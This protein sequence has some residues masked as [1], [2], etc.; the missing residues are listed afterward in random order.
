MIKTLP[1]A[2][3]PA[4]S[5]PKTLRADARKPQIDE[6]SAPGAED[7]ALVMAGLDNTRAA[8]R[9]QRDIDDQAALELG[10]VAGESI[11]SATGAEPAAGSGAS[12]AITI[13]IAQA[14]PAGA[15]TA[16]DAS[17]KSAGSGGAFAGFVPVAFALGGLGLIMSR[18]SGTSAPAATPTIAGK[19]VDGYI[20]GATV[21]IDRNKNG[22]LD[23]DEP[24]TKSDAQGNFTLP[25]GVEGTLVSVGGRDISTNLDFTGV[26]KAPAGSTAVTPLTT[27]VSE[28]M[29]SR[30]LSAA[31]A[32]EQVLDAV[33]L[34]ALKGKVD[35]TTLDPVAAATAGTAGALD[36]Q[37]AGVAVASLVNSLAV[38]VQQAANVGT[39]KHDEIA[40]G[41][42]SELAK[43]IGAG[44]LASDK[45]AA[46]ASEIVNTLATQA[47]I[48]GVAVGSANLKAATIAAIE[49]LASLSSKLAAATN[50][51]SVASGQKTALTQTTYTLQLLHFS[52]AEAGALASTTAP[53]LAALVDKFEDAYSNS[54]TL[55]GGD[56]FL[57]GPFL[58]AGTDPSIIT[59]LNAAGGGTLAAT[60][61]VPIAA[62]D[63]AIHNVIGVE[64]SA[65]GN[66]EF[67]LG[68][69]VLSDAI[70]GASGA[71]GAQF[72]HITA[73]L[74]FSGDA[75]LKS[76]YVDTT[77][78]AGLEEASSLKGKIAP[79]AILIENGAKIGLV[80]VTTQIL[81][82]I[83][84]PSG[85]EVK[86]FPMGPGPN[87][88]A[89]DMTLLASQLQ[90]VI[91]DLSNQGVNKI[92]LLS[93]L[94]IVGN[95]KLLATK[96]SGVD[97]IVAAGS[98]TRMGDANDKAVAFAGHPAAFAESYPH[99][100]TDKDGATTLVVSTDNEFTYLGRL[101][102]DFNEAGNVVASSL[103]ANAAVNG[104]WAATD[105]N[106][107]AAWGVA[108]SA[109]ATT[110]YAAGTRGHAVKTLTDAVQSVITVKDGNVLGYA[111]VYLEGE[112]TA[113]RSEETNL[114]NLSADANLYAAR[115]ALGAAA[116]STP[117]V[118]L[119]N[120]GGIRAQIGTLSNPKADGTVDKLAPSD[121]SVSLLDLENSLR[122]NNQLMMFDTTPEGLKA[123]LE[124]GVAA[125][126]LQGRFP[127][128]GGVAFSWDPDFA[129]GARVMDIALV[130]AD[131]SRIGLYDNGSKLASAPAKI[132]VVTLSFLAQGGDSYPIKANA[133]NFRYLVDVA[134]GGY[135]LS[136]AVPEDRDFT[137]SAT[138]TEFAAGSTVS[139]E[140][141]AFRSYLSAS[142]GTA[143]TAFAQADTPAAYDERIQNLNSRTEGVLQPS[144]IALAKLGTYS[145]GVYN[146]AG[147]EIVAFD[148][149]TKRMFLVNSVAAELH[150]INVADPANPVLAGKID[151]K[152]YATTAGTTPQVN[153]VAVSNGM[154]A[155]AVADA[156]PTAAGKVVLFKADIAVSTT[157][158]A[159]AG[160]RAL[161][162][163][164]GPDM[165]TFTP[166]G[167]KVL[168]ANEAE[169]INE[170]AAS[171]PYYNGGAL[172]VAN[173]GITVVTLGGDPASAISNA[174]AQQLD[175]TAYNGKEGWLRER[176]VRIAPGA[177]A[178]N[179]LEPEYIAVSPD[180]KQAMVT[181]QENNAVA[182]LDLSAAN[183]S[184]VD[185]VPMGY[186]DHARGDLVMTA[187]DTM[188]AADLPSIGTD[189][190]G[191]SVP[192]GGF[193]G[194]HYV[195]SNNGKLRFL[196]VS[197]RGPNGEPVNVDSDAALE[198]PFVLPA[199]QARVSTLEF[200]PATKQIA[201]VATTLLTRTDGTPLTGLPNIPG[202]D[203]EPVQI[204][205]ATDASRTGTFTSGGATLGYKTLSYDPLGADLE[206]IYQT[207]TGSMWMVDEYRPSVYEFDATGKMV[208]RFV[209]AG[210]AALTP[211]T[212]D[213]FG[214]ETLPAHLIK[215]QANRGFEALAVDESRGLLFAF[216]Q[217]P[218]DSVSG[219]SVDTAGPL[220]R[221][222]V[223]AMRDLAAGTA[224]PQGGT[225]SAAASKGTVIAEYAYLLE[226][227][228]LNL[229]ALD[230]IGD[231]VF[232]PATGTIFVFERDSSVAPEAKK[233]LYEIDL[234]GATNLLSATPVL[235]TG[236][237]VLEALTVD[238]LLAAGINPVYKE[239]IANLPSLGFTP[240]DKAEGLALLP[241]GGLA[242]INDND[243]GV[244][245]VGTETVGFGLFQFNGANRI[246][247]DNDTTGQPTG[248]IPA[249]N[250]VSPKLYGAYMP[251]A[252]ASFSVNGKTYYITANEGDSRGVDEVQV[253]DLGT[254][255]K[256]VADVA[257][258][259]SALDGDL[260]VITNGI[261][262]DGDG[263][264]DK[265]VAFGG[266]SFSI[267]DAYGNRIYDSGDQIERLMAEVLPGAFNA[268]HTSN[269]VDNRSDDK[270]PEPEAVTTA[271]VGDKVYA[272]V[273]LE[274]MGGV[275]VYDVTDPYNPTFASYSNT[276]NF[277]ETPALG[278]GG[279]LGPEGII[280]IPASASPNGKPMIAVANEVSGT[281][282]LFNIASTPISETDPTVWM[283][284]QLRNDGLV[285]TSGAPSL[286]FNHP[287]GGVDLAGYQLTG[288]FALPAQPAAANKLAHEASA[289]TYNRDTDSLFVLGDGGTAIAQVT[290]QGVLIDSMA[291]A[292]GSSAQGTY[293]Y[294]TEGIAYL[295]NGR[296]AMVEERD[297]KLNEF[298]YQAGGTL[299]PT[300]AVRSVKMGTSI[301]NIGLEGLSLDPATGGFLFAKEATPMGVFQSTVDFA[302]GTASNG[303]PT[304][305]NAANLFD[306][307]KTGLTS[308]N[309]IF[310]LSNVTQAGSADYNSFLLLSAA[311][312]KLLK[313]DRQ[314]R[315][316]GSIS[317]A[318]AAKNEGVTMDG[319]S[320][321]YIVGEEGGGSIDKP[322][323]LV[324]SPTVHGAAVAPGANLYLSFDQPVMAGS[325]SIVLKD[326]GSDVRT[327]SVSDT[328]QV[329]ITGTL[330]TLN[331]AASL[332]AGTSYTV[333]YDA[334]VFKGI[335][336]IAMDSV[337]AGVLSFKT[338]GDLLAPRLTLTSPVNGAAGITSHH[339]ILTFDEPVK[340]GSGMITLSGVNS[341]GLTDVRMIPVGDTTQVTISGTTVDINPSADLRNGYTYTVSIGGGVITDLVGNAYPGFTTATSLRYTRNTGTAVG[342]QTVIVSEV[343]SNA[344][345]DFFELYNYGTEA[346]SL[347]GWKWDDDS[348]SFTDAAAVSFPAGTTLAAGA[349]LVVVAGTDA[350]AF[351]TTW[352]LGA[353]VP[354]VATGGPGLGSGD[355][356]VVFNQ[357]GQAVTALN[358]G[359]SAKTA[360]D[361]SAIPVAAP[362]AGI[363]L[364]SAASHAGAAFGGTATASAVWDG[365]SITAPTYRPATV[366]Q[367]GAFAQSAAAANIGS[368]G[369]IAAPQSAD[370]VA[371][372]LS[373][374][375]PIKSSQS[376]L[377]TTNIVLSFSESV[378]VG[379]GNIVI[380][381][382]A[383][384]SDTRTIPVTDAAQVA[385]SSGVVTVNP[386]S[387][388][389]PGASY[390]VQMAAGVIEDLAGNDFAG[391]LG[392]QSIGF[393]VATQ[394]PKLLITE[395]N[396][397][398]GP[399][400][401]FELYN[402]GSSAISLSG[403]RWDDD[404]ASFAEG[405]AFPAVSIPAGK[406]L[407]VASTPETDAALAAFKSAWGLGD[408]A[409]VITSAGPGLGGGD[410]V[411]L[412]N[413]AGSVVAS[414]NYS[415]TA[416]LATD[417]TS[418]AASKAATGVTFA[419]S[420]HAG[421]AY[422]AAV[423]ANGVSAVW[424]GVSTSDPSYLAATVGSLGGYAQTGNAANIGSPGVIPV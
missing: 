55:V 87:G 170:R 245:G 292:A 246:D 93:H 264:L 389:K 147:A 26:M 248:T 285:G 161:D 68:S 306:P 104:A 78:T 400:D 39:D 408:S 25:K 203:E 238:E 158:T 310:A 280:A 416:K 403:W 302:A 60:A 167:R 175:F 122:F 342:P 313:M 137:A 40:S 58:G 317:F 409:Q 362:S 229:G 368:P 53:K 196:S 256:P 236:K 145:A 109:L 45:I 343:N 32:Q 90:P 383:D 231:A 149:A 156:N 136:A 266:R 234:R 291:L 159:P 377:A 249:I 49:N 287:A 152:G 154:V 369:L 374:S 28:L 123:I 422:G 379:T 20:S 43:S 296:F 233:V 211:D 366:G 96:L 226:R 398:A 129:A 414:F 375:L 182:V 360:S 284:G 417:G 322:E 255:G 297:R 351:K 183:A 7:A 165:L 21:F 399:S 318:A 356:V 3:S 214:T 347:D 1:P 361:G 299:G 15:A 239:R 235:P 212:S 210:T 282:S 335:T 334:G 155:V 35:L 217:S 242:V 370:S 12:S 5:T 220:I 323:M 228:T 16:S 340:A 382:T 29:T 169:A 6:R 352:G 385:I 160:A 10:G 207:A 61:T 260:K 200:D 418:V 114:G 17:A 99:A 34:S 198:R 394:S 257:A 190:F 404:S 113:V 94:Q 268:N 305:D 276:R 261:D 120:G 350:A 142:F 273:G 116:P 151:F 330:V 201:I 59:A 184:I 125:G 421:P 407:V 365:V 281:V 73:N 316:E 415:G 393:A 30:N 411:V 405:K 13:E 76:I 186:K 172:F 215:R 337:A 328:T 194:L 321:I 46:T 14:S 8:N 22:Q 244:N 402:F 395:L 324:Y 110:A 157:P 396:S 412:F 102:V 275:A 364:A 355:A 121:N 177:A 126:T 47:T 278:K 150:V 106:V 258:N 134:G 63:I 9:D 267:L 65:V 230:K 38:K 133:D 187:Y 259:A 178:S 243:F 75:D 384:A 336:G 179:D 92:I 265:L 50:V 33:G 277:S 219:S 62:V 391:L 67:D 348:A 85:T 353:E 72:P 329:S 314:G 320:N 191:K 298:V 193:S 333:S 307:A 209:P 303:S 423:G 168:V 222:E 208:S 81:E 112:R 83:S 312:G 197:D 345:T 189:A 118:S 138:T 326:G 237:T 19:I 44:K 135:K 232:N 131:G 56:N 130:A 98:N 82:S 293:F 37:K 216:V 290:K 199:Y 132:S 41:I 327:I 283:A 332:N 97:I 221:I 100:A 288:R 176:G 372:T 80:G 254:T 105:A 392:D 294:D 359:I 301:G 311:D 79:S 413:D 227:P 64:A 223:M 188:S 77:A 103:T 95:E 127:Q 344:G 286:S 252:I 164:F 111:S 420:S 84:S 371:P 204:V 23:A 373:S 140:Q 42:F 213:T 380:V 250:L 349:R 274:R 119:K 117:I 69:R 143:Q 367:L 148:A 390:S 397:N 410:A 263:D 166:D 240:N 401:Y 338:A 224:L 346:V 52:D 251:D 357:A 74:D 162:A 269:S 124:H 36:I 11:V 192:A 57:P 89:D 308:V 419:A 272:F 331:P 66:H 309:D 173:G 300:S 241:N 325:G 2:K 107:A 381:N 180:G 91:N 195:G 247:A 18:D 181:L 354:V 253:K 108:E 295:G 378:K 54:I 341:G 363:T 163:G 319:A 339:T 128:I 225:L 71:K 376:A 262:V 206:G 101:V 424:D 205:P 315:T 289:V 270:G 51:D 358:Y 153:S 4:A 218:L 386:T 185:I 304:T 146:A 48:A 86:G 388:L 144:D 24:S 70:K 174:T 115:Q 31:A 387:N 406:S 88:E 202:T 27:L 271:V 141:A 171:D 139:S 279:D